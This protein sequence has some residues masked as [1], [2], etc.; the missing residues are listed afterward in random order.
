M[1]RWPAC[2]DSLPTLLVAH[3]AKPA[4]SELAEWTTKRVGRVVSR[5]HRRQKGWAKSSVGGVVDAKDS[6]GNKKGGGETSH[7]GREITTFLVQ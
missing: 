4:S 5:G 3:E 2:N 7:A 6:V 1:S